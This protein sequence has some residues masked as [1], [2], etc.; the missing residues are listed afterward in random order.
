MESDVSE[1]FEIKEPTT[2]VPKKARM[3]ASLVCESC[4]E[5]VMETRT[6]RFRDKV[7]CIPCFDAVEKR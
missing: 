7:L 6:R 3:V 2:P 4:G 1:I 5:P